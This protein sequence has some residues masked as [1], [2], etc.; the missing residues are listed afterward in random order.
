M[1]VEAQSQN[2]IRQTAIYNTLLNSNKLNSPVRFEPG[3]I[4]RESWVVH[5]QTKGLLFISRPK[6]AR[7]LKH[8]HDL[9]FWITFGLFTFNWDHLQQ[10]G[11]RCSW[12]RKMLFQS[13]LAKYIDETYWWEGRTEGSL[14][15]FIASRSYLSCDSSTRSSRLEGRLP[16]QWHANFFVG[17]E[18]WGVGPASLGSI[19]SSIVHPSIPF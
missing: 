11:G 14:L 15:G 6:A 7:C 19:A 1:R 3:T 2:L 10:M 12:N 4:R 17:E 9:R 13:C 8:W 18:Y 5:K 16:A